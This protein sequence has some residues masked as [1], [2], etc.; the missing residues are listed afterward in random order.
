MSVLLAR[1]AKQELISFSPEDRDKVSEAI[2]LLEN[3]NYRERNKI[4]LC[5]MQDGCEIWGFEVDYIWLAFHYIDENNIC[6]DWASIK[7]KFRR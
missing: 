5:I 1:T 3:D 7:S 4:D 6:V 2:A